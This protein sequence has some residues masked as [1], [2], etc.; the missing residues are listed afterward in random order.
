M[1]QYTTKN[2]GKKE[3]KLNYEAGHINT[4]PN[5]NN[6]AHYQDVS[7]WPT[8]AA[9]F[10][11]LYTNIIENTYKIPVHEVHRHSEVLI[12]SVTAMSVLTNITTVSG[13]LVRNSSGQ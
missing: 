2:N 1:V 10:V 5:L 11:L 3:S 13:V 12:T 4:A 6:N 7:I 8:S 9:V